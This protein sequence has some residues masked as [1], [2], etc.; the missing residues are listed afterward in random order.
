MGYSKKER[1][2]KKKKKTL[3]IKVE[4]EREKRIIPIFHA[5]N[6]TINIS[7]YNENNPTT[8]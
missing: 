8:L 7:S 4:A 3:Q 1:K 2:E 6:E 5:Q